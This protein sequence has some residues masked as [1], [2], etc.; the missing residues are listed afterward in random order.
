[1][2]LADLGSERSALA[3][4]AKPG[5]TSG[6]SCVPK[7]AWGP[8]ASAENCMGVY[9]KRTKFDFKR[10]HILEINRKLIQIVISHIY[11]SLNAVR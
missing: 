5:A 9:L 10:I 1:M 3:S 7:T 11:M 6:G 4:P 8:E 2:A